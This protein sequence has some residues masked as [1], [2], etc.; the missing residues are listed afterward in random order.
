MPDTKNALERLADA[1]E[2]LAQNKYVPEHWP[3]YV[4]PM[5]TPPGIV[6]HGALEVLGRVDRVEPVGH[7]VNLG[8]IHSELQERLERRV[9]RLGLELDHAVQRSLEDAN[10]RGVLLLWDTDGLGWDVKLSSHVPPRTIV[11][12]RQDALAAWAKNGFPV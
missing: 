1:A 2:K 5:V 9:E 11:E 3:D 6:N 4:P 8:R 7:Q 12:I 10:Q